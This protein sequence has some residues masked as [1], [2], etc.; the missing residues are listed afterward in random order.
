[1]ATTSKTKTSTATTPRDVVLNYFDALGR[2]DIEAAKGHLDPEVIE[3]ITGVGV[4]RGR[5]EV[6]RFFDGLMKA[7]PDMELI[8]DRTI[9]EDDVVAIQWR[10]NGTFSGGPLFNGVQPTGGQLALRG[11][12]VI[13]VK[14]GLIVRNT[15][16][17]DGLELARGLG[18]MPPQDSATERAMIGA[19]NLA[20]KVRQAARDR[21]GS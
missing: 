20:T 10:M 15:A 5:D 16:F 6:G 11:C 19:F 9:A 8:V 1:M 17:Q 12:D 2:H 14:G 7:A 13:E 4:L 3:E 21:F 18:L